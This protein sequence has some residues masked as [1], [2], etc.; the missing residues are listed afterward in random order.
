MLIMIKLSDEEGRAAQETFESITRSLRPTQEDRVLA[1]KASDEKDDLE[2]VF[3]HQETGLRPNV[4][5]GLDF[6]AESEIIAFNGRGVYSREFPAGGGD[7]VEH[8]QQKP[9]VCGF[10]ALSGAGWFSP[11]D[12]IEMSDVWDGYGILQK[13]KKTFEVS[14]ED[15]KIAGTTHSR[16]PPLPAGKTFKGTW[17]YT[18]AQSGQTAYSS[19]GFATQRT[20]TLRPDGGF[21]RSGFTSVSSTHETG[22]STT[23][24]TSSSEQPAAKGHY[25]VEGYR[26]RLTG[27][28]GKAQEFS[29]FSLAGDDDGV[30]VIGGSNYI[31]EDK[32]K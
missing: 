10:Y 30:L 3:T 25:E 26:I 12:S 9:Q 23:G 6:Y 31:K 22:G 29:F 15:I 4:F 16:L 1:F 5:G 2:G 27:D 19:G 20:L 17:N 7:I 13:D 28:D 32:A 11:D 8:C 18:F 21:E 14:G 24:V